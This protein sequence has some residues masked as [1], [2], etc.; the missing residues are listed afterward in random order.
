MIL[1]FLFLKLVEMPTF[2]DI[3]TNVDNAEVLLR[4]M[5]E[6]SLIASTKFCNNRHIRVDMRL[7]INMQQW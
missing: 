1:F 5:M 4:L 7:D 6:V 3:L 2:E